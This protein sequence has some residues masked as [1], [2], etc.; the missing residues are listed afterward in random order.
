MEIKINSDKIFGVV[1]IFLGVSGLFQIF[2]NIEHVYVM[3][4]SFLY[5]NLI[6]AGFLVFIKAGRDEK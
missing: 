1:W 4:L 2:F 3:N 6:F 5:L